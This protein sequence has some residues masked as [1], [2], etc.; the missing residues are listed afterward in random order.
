MSRSDEQL[1]NCQQLIGYDF[2]NVDLLRKALVHA[3]AAA[4]RIDSNERLEFLGDAIFGA[5]ICD[6][7]FR[8][9]PR[10][11]EGDLT[12]IKSSTVSR[13]MC[14]KVTMKIG[15]G[16]YVILGK[17]VVSRSGRIPSSILAA[18]MESVIAAIYLD[19]GYEAARQFI[20]RVFDSELTSVADGE[21]E[22]NYK[23]LLQQHAQKELGTTPEYVVI[24]EQG[25]D[26]LKSFQVAAQIEAEQ[27]EPAWGKNK[28][29][30][31]QK[32][33]FNA[34]QILDSSSGET[35]TPD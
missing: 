18:V 23:S 34:L 26:H 3:S 25:P 6:E 19:G 7:L 4:T 29:E 24:D 8:R 17:G 14:V 15:L 27:F 31:E 28:K 30:A 13:S 33:A 9:Y 5:V 20:V 22:E 32:A 35:S 1:R 2:A 11:T 12:R 21:S 16:D 10:K